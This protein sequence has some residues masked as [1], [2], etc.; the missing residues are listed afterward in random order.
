MHES[1]DFEYSGVSGTPKAVADALSSF[2][3]S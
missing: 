1:I 3:L 2:G